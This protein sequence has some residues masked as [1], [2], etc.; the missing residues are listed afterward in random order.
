MKKIKFL[1]LSLFLT[2]LYA[3]KSYS[4]TTDKQF[5]KVKIDYDFF[6]QNL[7]S[8]NFKKDNKNWKLNRKNKNLQIFIN[9]IDQQIL[10]IKPLYR[11]NQI[12]KIIFTFF[13]TPSRPFLEIRSN[14]DCDIQSI[15]KI[16]YNEK[17]IPKRYIL[18]TFLTSK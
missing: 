14:K 18:L 5:L 16:I 15:R 8:S 2:I 6:C 7:S 11:S 10:K 9:D 1:L 12:Q 4:I 17:L 3:S 13:K